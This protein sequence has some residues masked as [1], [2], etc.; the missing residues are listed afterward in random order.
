SIQAS[1]RVGTAEHIVMA[2][3]LTLTSSET[4][5]Q[6]QI[7]ILP[8]PETWSAYGAK[9]Q[10]MLLVANDSTKGRKHCHSCL[11]ILVNSSSIESH[12]MSLLAAV[13]EKWSCSLRACVVISQRPNNAFK[14]KPLR[15]TKHM[16][17]KACHVFGSTTRLGLT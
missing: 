12:S 5:H 10:C 3:P 16:A 13:V 17:G 2:V 8:F 1:T 4:T 14:P 6:L 9:I 7:A 11:E 15:S